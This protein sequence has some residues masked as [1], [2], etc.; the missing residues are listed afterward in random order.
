MI[1]RRRPWEDS[2]KRLLANNPVMA[3]RF[4]MRWPLPLVAWVFA[5][6]VAGYD[7][8]FA[9]NYR[10]VL[11]SWEM[12]P[13]VRWGADHVG[14]G[15]VFIFKFAGL[16]LTALLAWRLRHARPALSRGLTLFVVGV[17]GLLSVHY[18][19]DHQS[20]T[21]AEIASRSFSALEHPRLSP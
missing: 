15:G 3:T 16:A 17:Y 19:I 8:C 6:G 7:C 10:V 12:N 11:A 9:W 21:A 13:L 2:T 20:P 14:L 4:K 5:L 1:V 18:L